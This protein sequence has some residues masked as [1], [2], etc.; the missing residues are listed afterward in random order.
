MK[1]IGGYLFI[2]GV[3]SIVLYFLNMQFVVL[4]WI[5]NWGPDLAWAIRGA[6]TLVGAALWLFAKPQVAEAASDSN[7][8][9]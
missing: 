5:D 8:A 9:G 2:F 3:G 1:T 7:T 6:M 4:S